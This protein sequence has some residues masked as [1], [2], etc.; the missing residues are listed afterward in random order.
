M[1][2]SPAHR[3]GQIIGDMLE[4]AIKPLLTEFVQE[5]RF[6]LDSKGPRPARKS[7]DVIWIDGRGNSHKLDYVLERDGTPVS[8]GLPVAFIEV[9][10]RRYTKHSKNKAQEIEAAIQPLL[11]KHR[12]AAPFFGAVLGGIFTSAALDQLRSLGCEL[13]YFPYDTVIAAFQRVNIDASSEEKTPRSVFLEKIIAWEA[14]SADQHQQVANALIEFNQP[15]IR[16]FME[17]LRIA[18]LR[19]I[20]AIRILSLYGTSSTFAAV[21][22]A[23]AF[24]DSGTRGANNDP[25]VRYEIQIHFNNGSIIEA[26]FTDKA[27]TLAF[28]QGYQ[29]PPIRST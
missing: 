18:A 20:E 21:Q 11:I 24:I 6:Y 28:L 22:D 3:W 4:A 12:E 15:Q 23:L 16:E 9:A 2:E 13:I 19:T 14:L 5:H 7:L 1:A 25:F 17:K 29:P 27:S 26:T 10:W 8:I